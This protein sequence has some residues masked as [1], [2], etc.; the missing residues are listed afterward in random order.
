MTPNALSWDSSYNSHLSGMQ[1]IY[2]MYDNDRAGFSGMAR[3]GKHFTNRCYLVDWTGFPDKYDLGDY[4][5]GDDAEYRMELLLDRC[6]PYDAITNKSHW[7]FYRD[8][9]IKGMKDERELV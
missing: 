4:L 1:S 9:R 2:L 7:N 8:L 3:V 5:M 6:L